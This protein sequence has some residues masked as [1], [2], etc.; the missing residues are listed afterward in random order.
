MNEPLEYL[1]SARPVTVRRRARWGECDPA[2]VVYTPC[3]A[4]FAISAFDYFMAEMV[5]YPAQKSMLEHG[6]GLPMKAMSFEFHFSIWPDQTFDMTVH[7][8]A[9]RTRSFDMK[10]AAADL[11]GRPLFTAILSPVCIEPARRVSVPMPDM[12]R[13]RLED[14]AAVDGENQT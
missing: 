11:D 8:A 7:V 9:I 1:L 6:F 13:R 3:F 4:D 2:G 5:G 10:V 14:Y 12:L